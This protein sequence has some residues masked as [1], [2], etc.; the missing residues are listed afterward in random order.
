MPSTPHWVEYNVAST[1]TTGSRT[2][3]NWKAIDDSTTA[4]SAQPITAG[5]YSYQKI[6]ALVFDTGSWNGLSSFGYKCN[7]NVTPEGLSIY[8]TTISAWTAPVST[9]VDATLL[10]TAGIT[11]NFTTGAIT[12]ANFAA[13]TS[14]IA[15]SS[16]Q[17]VST[18]PLRSQLKSATS[19][20]PGD[21]TP[22]TI[23]ATWT[24]S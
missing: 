5:N 12:S 23:T 8:G 14:S 18:Q 10:S 4:Y 7:T 2:E 15:G 19:S 6:Q 3:V 17:P 21:I 11:A 1:S 20:P 16:T 9:A 22:V 13:G 24:E